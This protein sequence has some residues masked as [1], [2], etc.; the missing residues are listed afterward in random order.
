MDVLRVEKD[1]S[2]LVAGRAQADAQVELRLSSG[3]VI[4]KT[5]AEGE[6]DFIV[7]SKTPLQPGDY[8][9]SVSSS[10]AKGKTITSRESSIV[11]IPNPGG[12]L[13][14]RITREDKAE[15]NSA[16]PW[17]KGIS[18]PE[19]SIALLEKRSSD[20]AIISKLDSNRT[21]IRVEAVEVEGDQVF[22]A[23]TAPYGAHV[24]I[25]IDNIALGMTR[26]KSGN[27][28][29]LS[30]KFALTTGQHT[31]RVDVVNVVSGVVIARAEVPLLH[32]ITSNPFAQITRPSDKS[33]DM[34]SVFQ[35]VPAPKS[36][37]KSSK[38]KNNENTVISRKQ[39]AKKQ[40]L[41]AEENESSYTPTKKF[42]HAGGNVFAS[43]QKQENF[44]SKIFLPRRKK[45]TTV[46]N[47]SGPD[48]FSSSTV[49]SNWTK[50]L[51]PIRTGTTVIIKRGDNLWRIARK[52]YGRGIRYTT[53]YNANRDQIADPNLIYVGQ[54]FKLPKKITK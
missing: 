33:V 26:G 4:G 44:P 28:F 6:G 18:K 8:V 21:E 27:R 20:T 23:G 37:T 31:V 53:I 41:R 40:P 13:L 24:Q 3:K 14:A 35:N 32:E 22:V 54:V 52:T 29:W 1:G 45:S 30:K 12:E 34:K 9:L 5:R 10:N 2:I 25:Y 49:V 43:K 46:P 15:V 50:R 38:S 17:V 39:T 7:L 19:T 36:S 16:K 48:I 42:P 51:D 47:S 11:H